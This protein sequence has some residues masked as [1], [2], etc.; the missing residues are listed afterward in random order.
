MSGADPYCHVQT[1]ESTCRL[2]AAVMQCALVC[3]GAD[4]EKTSRES[5][6]HGLAVSKEAS[7]GTWESGGELVGGEGRSGS[8]GERER[9]R[10]VPWVLQVEW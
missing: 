5:D 3:E 2:H 9:R 6:F 10:S 4:A 8:R 7:G 1:H